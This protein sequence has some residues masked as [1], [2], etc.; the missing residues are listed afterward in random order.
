MCLTWYLPQLSWQES[1]PKSRL[2]LSVEQHDTTAQPEKSKE[3]VVWKPIVSLDT[4][5][6]PT[7]FPLYHPKDRHQDYF[8][9]GGNQR[10]L[11]TPNLLKGDIEYLRDSTGNN[12]IIR[13]RVGSYDYRAPLLLSEREMRELQL[14]YDIRKTFQELSGGKNAETATT[15]KNLSP[16]IPIESPW[17]DRIFGGDAVEFK[18]V[19]F[20]N[21]DFGL[22]RQK[23]ANPNLPIRQQRVTNFNFDPH[24]NV[25]L[26]GNVGKKLQIAGSFDTKSSFSFENNFKLEYKG[27]E[28]DI[29]RKIE[30]GNV[31]FPLS[32]TLIQGSQSLF[33]ISTELQF[34]RL[35]VRSTFANQ[36]SRAESIQLDGGSQKRNFEI[37]A[38]D[39]EDNRHFFLAQFFR[40]NYEFW[41]RSLP[42]VLS[43]VQITRVE[44]YITNRV[45]NTED[46]RNITAFLD[47]GEARP[48]KALLNS[49]S[50]N[51]AARRE[52]N[53]LSDE[54]QGVTR[55]ADNIGSELVAKGFVNGED[56]TVLR[57]ARKLAS[58]EYTFNPQLGYLSLL[59]PLRN[60]EVLA[61]AF[62]YTYNG[63]VYR[64]GELTDD[65]ANRNPEEVVRLKMLRPSSIRLDLPTWDLMMKNIY[66]L[67][68]GAVN[69]QNFLLR[70]VYKDDLTGID[71]PTLQEGTRLKDVPLLRVV[72]LD[73]LNSQNDPQRDGNFDFVE[74]ITIDSRNGRI[75]F[76]VLEP[77]GSNLVGNAQFTA[78]PA[79]IKFDPVN[80]TGLISKYIFDQLYRSTKADA[81]QTADKNKFFITGY[82]EGSSATGV[83]LPGINIPQGSVKVSMGG[84]PLTEG[85]D[86]TVDY[87]TGQVTIVNQAIDEKNIT[88]DYEKA[89]L[90][91]FQQRRYAATR[92]EYEVFKDP[93]RDFLI[94]ASIISLRERPILTRVNTGE[95]PVNNTML[96]MDINYRSKSR[97]LTRLVDMLPMIQTKAESDI[98]LYAEYAQL[99]PSSSPRSQDVSLIDDFEGTRT[100]FNF[101]R[102]PQQNWKL[103]ATPQLFANANAQSLEYNFR[104]AKLAWYNV[105]NLFYVPNSPQKPDNINEEN[106]YTR[107]VTPQE[108]F[109]FR[110]RQQIQQ[111]EIIFDLAFYP[112]E[113]GQY[114]YNPDITAAGRLKN[115]RQNFGAITRAITSDID[116]DNANVEYLEFWLL[117]P[118]IAGENGRVLDGIY[119]ENNTTGADLY[120]NLGNI[121]EDIMPDGR[122]AFENGLPAD[123]DDSKT[124]TNTWGKVTNQQYLNNAFDNNENAR[125][126]Q[127]IGLDGLNNEEEQNHSFFQNFVTAV[128]TVVTDQQRRDE[129]LA[130][131]SADNFR[132][133][134][135]SA[136]DAESLQILERYKFFNGMEGNTPIVTSNTGATPGGST[137]PDNEDLNIDNTIS[138]IEGYYQYK[139]PVRPNIQVGDK[140]VVD[141]VTSTNTINNEEMSWYLYR[142]PIREYDQRIGAING[143]KSIRYL[144]MFVTNAEKPIVF[145]FAQYQLVSNQWRRFTGDLSDR[146]FGLPTE[147]YD[148]NF[149]IATVNIEENG[150]EENGVTP[151]KTPPGVIRDLDVTQI[152][153]RQ[154]NEQS[155][156]LC[157]SGLRD[158]DARA[159]FR[160]YNLDFLS[161]KRVQMFLHAESEDAEDGQ[162]SAFIR[163]GTDFTDNYYEVEVPLKLT[164]RGTTDDTRI[165]PEENFIDVPFVD[166][167][168]TKV[169]RNR[170]GQSVVIPFSRIVG[171]YRITVVGNPDLS[172][173]VTSM[174]GIRNPDTEALSGVPDDK[175][176][177]SVCIWANEFRIK[178]FDQTAGWAALA[179]GQVRL[180]DFAQITGS[181]SYTTFGFGT[182]QQRIS[183]R[184]RETTLNYDI[185]ATIALDK[186]LPEKWGFKIPLTVGY[187]RRRVSPRFNPLDPDVELEESL[188]GI[189]DE[190]RRNKYEKL[191]IENSTRRN[192]SFTNVGKSKTKA[193]AKS[194]LWDIEN[195]RFT[196]SY[197]EEQRSDIR[198]ADYF[199]MQNQY[200]LGYQFSRQPKPIEPFKKWKFLDK[201]YLKFIKDFNFDLLPSTISVTGDI[202]RQFARTV[203]RASDLTTDGV[204]PLFQKQ[205]TF[206]RN[207]NVTWQ[208]SKKLGLTYTAAANAV[209]DEPEGQIDTEAE[210][211]EI[212]SNLKKLGRMKVF[213]QSV[214]LTYQLPIDKFPLLDWTTAQANYTAGVNWLAGAYDPVLKS[215]PVDTL[216]N[217]L[218]NNRSRTLGLGFDFVKLYNKS[219]F[220]KSV[221]TPPAKAKP[222]ADKDKKEKEKEKTKPKT[223]KDSVNNKKRDYWLLRAIVRPL[224]LIKKIN[225]NYGITEQTIFPGFRP[226]PRFLGLDESWGAPGIPFLLGSQDPSIRQ[227]AI[228]N[229]WLARGTSQVNPFAQVRQETFKIAANLEPSPDFRIQIDAERGRQANYTEIFR[230][231]APLDSIPEFQSLNPNRTGNYRVT[232][233]A[234]LTAFKGDNKENQSAIFER[235]VEYRE[236]I[237]NRLRGINPNYEAGVRDYALNSQEVLLPAFLAAYSGKD[238]EEVSLSPFPKIPLPNW[239]I[240]YRGLSNLSKDKSLTI[241]IKHSYKAE[242]NVSNYTSSLVYGEESINLSGSELDYTI[243]D[244]VN[245]QG[246]FIPVYVIGQVSIIEKFSPLI[247][248]NIK[249]KSNLSIG[250]DYNQDR[251]LSLN[252]SNAQLAEIRN[253]GLNIRIG[254]TKANVKLPFK[255]NGKQIV[256]KNDVDFRLDFTIRDTRTIQRRIDEDAIVTN[257]NLNFQLRP[258][259]NYTVNKQLSLQAYFEKNINEPKISTS[260][261]RSVTSGGIQLRYNITP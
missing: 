239:T 37:P 51:P 115:P 8:S 256:L 186:F 58:R 117:D 17:F 211:N 63:Q 242:Y 150:D 30:F 210:R 180:A 1:I 155:I 46:L 225:V 82:F 72:N 190:N 148:A 87:A 65:Y 171:K 131:V 207:Y 187:E 154:L 74:G 260:F 41:L 90:F 236:A 232:F 169:Q 191:V 120:I 97:F 189:S 144:R 113:R 71:N 250:L 175:L 130:D 196:W 241:D 248:I 152:N 59:T 212:I 261:R 183:E 177:K 109:P 213:N 226:A 39:Y 88:I 105:D 85:S 48:Y 200:T 118:F 123:G 235:F 108:V 135:G 149:T 14:D 251:D 34:G 21:L 228:R 222:T 257:G 188:R 79:Q 81:L 54:L 28:E 170:S 202:N 147:P 84:I 246:E 166:M 24:A 67:N 178:E 185:A 42:N 64:V 76:P 31:S 173:V 138:N 6:R 151:Y 27:Y 29:I 247:G 223:A 127:D 231:T 205:F 47:E 164:P 214:N 197:S 40:N 104:R 255:S 162:V 68:A 100:A 50:P 107:G 219:K 137:T 95:E 249:T 181:M 18:P 45:N 129:I 98:S 70:I 36:R 9:G 103:G 19:G 133:F 53:R 80:E 153:N 83:S 2:D 218:G 134:L 258:V 209:I 112:E 142:I 15:G 132:Y 49:N 195:L 208:L 157:V 102:A 192:I 221:L 89:D 161:Y 116:F 5:Y 176:P 204:E 38:G 179:R 121:S 245:E 253:K 25:T 201:P 124:T 163:L 244:K 10:P 160:N 101:V 206:N 61:V 182:I 184:A 4:P 233:I 52:A 114:N 217:T 20:V 73:R 220:L 227:D 159:V 167:T 12:Y 259:I 60:D 91:N 156:Q 94:G 198:T 16:K 237:L 55:N 93:A 174:I 234:F 33:G 75:I 243:P 69:Q 240:D 146:T 13:E 126:N 215:G 110:Q 122:H 139:I 44:L 238:V 96:G 252:L 56:F 199:R 119:N 125:R 7:R 23:V 203:F 216:G 165:W 43:G 158:K 168:D 193:D 254:F 136:Q 145:R 35:K 57:A 92:F 62:E 229:D 224:L 78:D 143:F 141:K 128:N 106:N 66:S 32:T 3:I 22:Q 77:F 11:Y 26:T 230:N 111:N 99:F 172:T 86:Y 140:Y 194:H